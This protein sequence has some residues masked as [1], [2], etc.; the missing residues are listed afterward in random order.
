MANSG[1]SSI[2]SKRMLKKKRA[3]QR[4]II[5]LTL[6]GVAVVA[7]VVLVVFLLRG[8][9]STPVYI[10]DLEITNISKTDAKEELMKKYTWDVQIVFQGEEYSV[11][12][13]LEEEIDKILE[14][15]YSENAETNYG[16][17]LENDAE[18]IQ[19]VIDAVN[20]KWSKYASNSEIVSFDEE[21]NEFVISESTEGYVI[22][23][24]Y[25]RE[26]LEKCF[27]S[28][29]YVARIEVNSIVQEPTITSDNIQMISTYTSYTTNNAAR[30]TNVRLSCEA[31]NGIIIQPG[32]QFSYND[33]LGKRTA[34]KGYQMAGAYANGEHVTEL[35]GGVCQLSS[36]LYNAAV[37]G[38][39]KIEER[40]GHTYEP[41]YVTPGQDATVSFGYPD[42]V[43]TNN[44]DF[45]IGI[46]VTFEDRTVVVEIY[47]VP[48]LED[49]VTRY[50]K[51]EKVADLPAPEANYVLDANLQPGEIVVTSAEELGS[52]WETYIVEE[53]DGEIISEEY[54]H[55]TRYK[56]N[57]ATIHYNL[58]ADGS[59]PVLVV[60]TPAEVTPDE[61]SGETNA[62]STNVEGESQPI[63]DNTDTL[64]E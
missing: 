52:K 19:E 8:K 30:N 22:D 43:F 37:D 24:N 11:P 26:E 18:L 61:M 42:F 15:A 1:K 54:F 3:R 16:I 51:S 27:S 45:P 32:E 35:G 33:T 6:L 25:L 40:V 41:T 5:K 34:E 36:T 12:N 10:D 58:C 17:A 28:D 2:K 50:M 14:Q 63:V 53:K 57:P 39:L 47:G 21:K 56:G 46:K 60:E 59:M 7:I 48:I 20:E 55:T 64:T 31:V 13:F 29:E 23:S 38:G 44:S 9:K 49:G 4:Q 62:D